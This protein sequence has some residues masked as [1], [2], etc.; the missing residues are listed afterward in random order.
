MIW[1]HYTNHTTFPISYRMADPPH[2]YMLLSHDVKYSSKV[3]TLYF[4]LVSKW[5]W[6]NIK[7]KFYSTTWGNKFEI[8]RSIWSTTVVEKNNV[9]FSV[10]RGKKQRAYG[11]KQGMQPSLPGITNSQFYI[12]ARFN[13]IFSPVCLFVC[14]FVCKQVYAKTT[15]QITTNLC[16]YL[17]IL[18][19]SGKDPI[20][21]G[22]DPDHEFGWLSWEVLPIHASQRKDSFSSGHYIIFL[23]TTQ[24]RRLKATVWHFGIS[25]YSLCN[26]Q[27]DE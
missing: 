10:K 11:Q 23:S 22:A 9:Q 15:E 20:N 3:Q 1:I 19:K 5:L 7:N 21:V 13:D 6:K 26:P 17:K 2:L 14:L 16:G 8:F 4:F 24:V 27:L 18:Y 25:A 12:K